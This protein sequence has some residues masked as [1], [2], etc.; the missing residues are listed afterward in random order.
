MNFSDTAF[1]RLTRT[2]PEISKYIISFVDLTTDLPEDRGLELGVFVL[3]TNSG[4][5]LYIPV[6]SKG[7][8]VFP[9]DTVFNPAESAFFPLIEGYVFRA[10]TANISEIGRPQVIPSQVNQNPSVRMLVDP[11][12]TG[13]HAYAGTMLEEAAYQLSP[14]FKKMFIEK[15]ASDKSFGKELQ[16]VGVDVMSLMETL[17]KKAEETTTISNVGPSFGLRVVTEGNGLPN[18][19]IQSILGHG[20]A[21]IGAHDNPRLAIQYDAVNDGYTKLT[22]AIEGEV[23]DVVMKDGSLKCGFV[24]PKLRSA[25]QIV[26]SG[27]SITRAVFAA[28]PNINETTNLSSKVIVFEDGTYIDYESDPVIKATSISSLPSVLARLADQGKVHSITDIGPTPCGCQLRGF[29]ITDR[30]WLGPVSIYKKSVNEIGITYHVS[31]YDGRTSHIHVSDNLHGSV[32]VNGD[33][34]FVRS[35][36]AFLECQASNT[37]VETSVTTASMKRNMFMM[38]NMLPMDMKR[39]GSDYYL[40]GA[41]V[42]QEL[43][44]VKRLAEEERIEANLINSLIKQ[45]SQNSHVRFWISKEAALNSIDS[46]YTMGVTPPAQDQLFD[47]VQPEFNNIQQAAGTNDRS[48]LE[49]TILSEFVN[50]PDMFETLGSYLPIIKEAID[51]LGRSIFL[52]RLNINDISNMVDTSYLSSTMIALRNTYRNLGD[53]YLK[54]SQLSNSSHE[55]GQEQAPSGEVI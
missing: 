53:S 46:S 45:A 39:E 54:L 30:G 31:G 25:G 38:Q 7:G 4:S 12:R 27:A 8:N 18:D 14:K 5:S 41:L 2:S 40:N 1:E 16:R 33:D 49:A 22:G 42:G 37:E 35:S 17:T 44:L 28:K 26:D 34:I 6:M 19:V 11:P 20:Y 48:I 55:T 29:V 21:F 47:N 10:I 9:I 13:K 24:P 23:Y 50:D 15:I 51:K 43:G 52:L 32:V 36:A 3:G